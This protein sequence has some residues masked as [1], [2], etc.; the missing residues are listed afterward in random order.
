MINTKFR[1]AVT[2]VGWWKGRKGKGMMGVHRQHCAGV[3]APFR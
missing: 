1:I 2:S 3:G